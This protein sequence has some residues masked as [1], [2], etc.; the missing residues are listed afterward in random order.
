MNVT[1]EATH[2]AH[3]TSTLVS[4]KVESHAPIT[5]VQGQRGL[6]SGSPRIR[7]EVGVSYNNDSDDTYMT[8]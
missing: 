3:L 6:G 8:P 4:V 7:G 2:Q 1:P 5:W